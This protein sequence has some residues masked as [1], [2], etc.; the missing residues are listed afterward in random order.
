ME[1]ETA[2]VSRMNRDEVQNISRIITIANFMHCTQ[3]MFCFKMR[4]KIFILPKLINY[5]YYYC[6]VLFKFKLLVL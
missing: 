4:R 5:H 1:V 3:I 2:E 6:S